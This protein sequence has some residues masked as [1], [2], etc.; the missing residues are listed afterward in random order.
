MDATDLIEMHLFV[1]ISTSIMAF[2]ASPHTKQKMARIRKFTAKI[3]PIPVKKQ[4]SGCR[5]AQKEMRKWAKE[6]A[7]HVPKN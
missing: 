4:I 3:R 2:R 6:G 7:K 1:R 5:S